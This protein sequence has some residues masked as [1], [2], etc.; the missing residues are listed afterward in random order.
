[1]TKKVLLFKTNRVLK[2]ALCTV[3]LLIRAGAAFGQ[4]YGLTLRSL[5][6][7][8]GGDEDKVEYTGTVVPWF[9]APLGEQGDVYLSGG[10]SAEYS[11][12]E[13]KAV[14]ELYRFELSY[15]FGS[16]TR[17]EAGRLLY[18]EP[19][20][21]VFNGLFDGLSLGFDWGKTRLSAGIFYTGLLYKKTVSITMSPG[22]YED[23]YDRDVY[24]ASRR[25]VFSLGWEIP[26][27]S[28]TGAKLDLGLT[29]QSDLNNRDDKVNSRYALA[30]FTIPFFNSMNTELG[31]VLGMID[32]DNRATGFCFA[33]SAG[34]AWL[35][36]GGPHDRLS[37]GAVVSSG[38]WNDTV[39]DFLP[40]NTI[41]QGKVLRPKL[42][43]LALTEGEYSAR[44]H[45][46][47]S[48]EISAAYFF[49]TDSYTYSDPGLDGASLSPLLGAEIYGGLTWAP[50]SDISFT[51]GGGAFLPQLGEAFKEDAPPQWR[52]A[53]ETI[54]SF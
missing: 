32:E 6:V 34:L 39:R 29:G 43:G 31:A 49:R 26:A 41:A 1:M 46:S 12:E 51:L 50:V 53:L 33:F 54:L 4:D 47:L 15:R 8:S 9:S 3:I 18:R 21:L 27:L 28:N 5:P 35:P 23:Y 2:L 38:A 11:D 44:I 10:I 25:L 42:S 52:I 24:F 37:L 45:G 14:P 30:G 48:A 7:F 20:N 19:L 17:L 36:S 13:W 22:D 16:G 40:L